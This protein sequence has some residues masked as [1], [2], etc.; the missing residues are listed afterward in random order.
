VKLRP[1]S[2]AFV[3]VV[4]GILVVVASSIALAA[5]E[6][7]V[8]GPDPFAGMS[9]AQQEQSISA[10]RNDFDA[11][12]K[13]W[14]ASLDFSAINY[15]ALERQP[16]LGLYEPPE[17]TLGAAKAQAHLI[18]L[19]KVRSIRPTAYDG[20]YVTLDLA[21]VL[22]G[23]ASGSIV[24]HQGGGIRPTPDWKGMFIADAMNAPLMLPNERVI[25]FLQMRSTGALEVQGF[26]GIYQSNSGRLSAVPGNPF[27]GDV[28]GA[29]ESDFIVTVKGQA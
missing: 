24:F 23:Q 11:R 16:I 22:K 19:G 25:V 13:A 29:L 14:L 10:G 28:N 9:D 5:A 7:K 12:Y 27:A 17:P 6:G 2:Q 26:T 21:A 8:V 3:G 1:S 18:V 4:L 20:T 15:K